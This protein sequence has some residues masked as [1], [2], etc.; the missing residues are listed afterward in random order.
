VL[1]AP[2]QDASASS[3]Q[4]CV[5]YLEAIG[6]A[7]SAGEVPTR[8]VDRGCYDST[9]A[10]L[11]ATGATLDSNGLAPTATVVIGIEWD[12]TGYSG[13]NVIYEVS[14]GC[15]STRTWV[16]SYVGDTWND[17]FASGKGYAHCNKNKKFE[18]ANFGGAVLVCTPNCSTYGVLNNEVS[19][20]KWIH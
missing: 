20:L 3:E 19:S 10:A 11:S 5:F 14:G 18:H 7:N 2:A 1:L 4:S 8:P 6:P 15:T 9:S 17:R 16:L 12:N 13:A